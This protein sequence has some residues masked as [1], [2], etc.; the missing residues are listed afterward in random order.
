MSESGKKHPDRD[1]SLVKRDVPER[2][3]PMIKTTDDFKSGLREGVFF[4]CE[5]FKQSQYVLGAEIDLGAW[6]FPF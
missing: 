6:C 4:L 5:V 1:S 2:P 3:V